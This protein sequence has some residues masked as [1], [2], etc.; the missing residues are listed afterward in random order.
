[1]GSII[2]IASK[3]FL[4]RFCEKEDVTKFNF[5]VISEDIKTKSKFDNVYALKRLIP[6]PNIVSVF[7]DKG[8]CK[9][10]KGMYL[11]YLSIPENEILLTSLVK[12]AVVDNTNVV[13]ICSEHE[14]QYMYLEMICEY[15][16]NI[17]KVNT[18]T[19]KQYKKHPGDCNSDINRKEVDYILKVKIKSAKIAVDDSITIDS[20]MFKEKLKDCSRKE[21][22]KFCKV[23]DI[24]FK[25]DDDK[26]QLIKRILKSA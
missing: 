3:D 9:K 11:D 26:P 16:E 22:L 18:V 2:K 24:K 23:N 25:K 8:F 20:K 19:Y 10:Y 12:C 1:M 13:L 4:K 7:V 6:P 14:K 21:L 5:L 17:Y 15:L